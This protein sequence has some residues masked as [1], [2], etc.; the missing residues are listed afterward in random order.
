MRLATALRARS[1]TSPGLRRHLG[2]DEA[3]LGQGGENARFENRHSPLARCREGSGEEVA[4]LLAV[5]ALAADTKHA[6]VVV[7]RVRYPD[8]SANPRVHLESRLEVP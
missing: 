8:P 4:G 5:P 3:G 7:L 6:R 1:V 2:E